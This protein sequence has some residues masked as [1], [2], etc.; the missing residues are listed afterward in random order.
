[1]FMNLKQAQLA[2]FKKQIYQTDEKIGVGPYLNQTLKGKSVTNFFLAHLTLDK[3]K[4][5]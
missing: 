5:P 4:R 3:D 2:A 1:M